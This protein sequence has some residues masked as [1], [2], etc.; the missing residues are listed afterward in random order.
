[1]AERGARRPDLLYLVAKL[2]ADLARTWELLHSRGSK[3]GEK[4]H[5]KGLWRW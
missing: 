5:W 4:R 1:V 2:A 3:R